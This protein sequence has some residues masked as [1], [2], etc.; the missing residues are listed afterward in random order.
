[1]NESTKHC[2]SALRTASPPTRPTEVLQG[3]DKSC[4]KGAHG[5]RFPLAFPKLLLTVEYFCFCF[6]ATE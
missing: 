1:M 6:T 2:F 3:F 4:S 5:I